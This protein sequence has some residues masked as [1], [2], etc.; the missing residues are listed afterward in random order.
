[1][2]QMSSVIRGDATHVHG[3]GRPGGDRTYLTVGGVIQPQ[4]RPTTVEFRNRR[5]RPRLHTHTL[6]GR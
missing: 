2:A 4:L 3:R 5:R 6:W 1:M